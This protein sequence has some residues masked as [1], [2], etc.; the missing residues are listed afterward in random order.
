MRIAS[1]VLHKSK[2]L[3]T[4]SVEA[5]LSEADATKTNRIYLFYYLLDYELLADTSIIYP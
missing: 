3:K 4:N 1:E 2:R 5:V